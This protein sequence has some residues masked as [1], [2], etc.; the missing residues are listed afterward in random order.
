MKIETKNH[1]WH[2]TWNTVKKFAVEALIG[3]VLWTLFLT[4]YMWLVVKTTLEQYINWLVM[5]AVIVPLIAI[6]VINATN[7]ITKKLGLRR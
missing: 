3:F 5:Q 7:W 1:V 2:I 6:V 4:P